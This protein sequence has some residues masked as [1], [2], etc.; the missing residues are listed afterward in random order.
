MQKN[1]TTKIVAIL[2]A[3]LMVIGILPLDINAAGIPNACP[4]EEPTNNYRPAE[5]YVPSAQQGS[6]VQRD[7]E[8]LGANVEHTENLS[9]EDETPILKALPIPTAI[10]GTSTRAVQPADWNIENLRDGDVW[11]IPESSKLTRVLQGEPVRQ[12]KIK[13]VGSYINTNGRLV[14]R[15]SLD[16]YFGSITSVWH[17]LVLKF[18]R[19]FDNLIEWD[20]PGTGMYTGMEPYLYHDVTNKRFS[21]GEEIRPFTTTYTKNVGTPNAHVMNLYENHN[22]FRIGL[23]ETFTFPFELV[24]NE[25][26]QSFEDLKADF[27]EEVLVQARLMSKDFS[28]IY[29]RIGDTDI[30]GKAGGIPSYNTYTLTTVIPTRIDYRK[31]LS[32]NLAR[33][34]SSPLF[35]MSGSY[36]LYNEQDGYVDVFYKSAKGSKYSSSYS[37]GVELGFRQA[38]DKAFYDLLPEKGTEETPAGI[39]FLTNQYDRPFADLGS[40]NSCTFTKDDIN[41]IGDKVGYLQIAS[42]DW[43]RRHEYKGG[44]KTKTVSRKLFTDAIINGAPSHG[45]AGISTV[46][47]Y[48]VDKAKLEKAIRTKG[49]E[50]FSFFSTFVIEDK[51]GTSVYSFTADKEYNIKKGDVLTLIFDQEQNKSNDEYKQIIIGKEQASIEFRSNIIR[52]GSNNQFKWTSPVNIRIPKGETVTVKSIDNDTSKRAQKLRIATT[53]GQF[54]NFNKPTIEYIP[55]SLEWAD[56]LTGG[57]LAK[58]TYLLDIKE[59]FDTDKK[60]EGNSYYKN[61]E[62]RLGLYNEAVSKS[63]EFK[64]AATNQ[65]S[66]VTLH[67]G[68][69]IGYKFTT[70]DPNPVKKPDDYEKEYIKTYPE[71]KLPVLK[72]DMPI[73]ASVKNVEAASLES[74]DVIEQVQAKIIFDL[75]NATRNKEK[76][77]VTKIVPLNIEYLY[78][79][80]YATKTFTKNDAYKYNGFETGNFRTATKWI[81]TAPNNMPEKWENVPDLDIN[82]NKQLA[83]HNNRPLTGAALKSRKMPVMTGENPEYTNE[84][85]KFLGWSTKPN[86]SQKDFAKAKELT[87][88]KQWK[89]QKAYKF[90]GK[91]PIDASYTVYAVW[92]QGVNL[93]LYGNKD[94]NDTEVYTKNVSEEDLIYDTNGQPFVFNNKK[95]AKLRIPKVFYNRDKQ[96]DLETP[97]DKAIFM[98]GYT[99]DEKAGRFVTVNAKGKLQS[100]DGVELTEQ[101]RQALLASYKNRYTMVG[102]TSG[103]EQNI[104]DN[105]IKLY[106]NKVINGVLDQKPMEEKINRD[107]DS[108]KYG[109]SLL[110]NGGNLLIP[111]GEDGKAQLLEDINLYAQY[112]PYYRVQIQ[113]K[114]FD[115]SGIEIPLNHSNPSGQ[116]PD[117]ISSPTVQIGLLHRTAVTELANPTVD[118]AADYYPISKNDYGRDALGLYMQYYESFNPNPKNSFSWYVPG[119]DEYGQRLSYVGVEFPVSSNKND[120]LREEVKNLNK[121]YNFYR[122]WS[123]V[124]ATLLPRTSEDDPNKYPGQKGQ[125][126]VQT[127]LI[128]RVHYG[129]KKVDT[130]TGSTQRLPVPKGDLTKDINNYTQAELA[131]AW[132][133]YLDAN[134]YEVYGYNII[135]TNTQVDKY[136]PIIDTVKKGDKSFIMTNFFKTT[137]QDI[138][139]EVIK[140]A[141]IEIKPKADSD[142]GKRVYHLDYNPNTGKLVFTADDKWRKTS[143]DP[144][145]SP[146]PI[147]DINKAEPTEI[148]PKI[149]INGNAVK[150]TMPETF[151]G[152]EANTN[153]FNVDPNAYIKASYRFN[154][155][156]A[157]FFT[158]FTRRIDDIKPTAPVSVDPETLVQKPSILDNQTNAEIASVDES[159]DI[160][161]AN[162]PTHFVVETKVPVP[163]LNKP[164]EGKTTYYLY[165]A[166]EFAGV[167]DDKFEE[168]YKNSTTTPLGTYQMNDR[169]K[170]IRF[171]VPIDQ[172]SRMV[173]DPQNTNKQIQEIDDLIIVG[174]E[175]GK[176]PSRS[177]A[178]RLDLTG[179]KFDAIAEEDNFRIFVNLVAE[180]LDNRDEDGTYTVYMKVG[181]ETKKF[182]DSQSF[183][184]YYFALEREGI[185]LATVKMVAFD[186][187]NNKTVKEPSYNKTELIDL[188]VSQPKARR[189]VVSAKSILGATIKVVVRNSYNDIVATGSAEVTNP[190]RFTR[191]KLVATEGGVY[192]LQEG[193]SIFVRAVDKLKPETKYSNEVFYEVY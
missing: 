190:E 101:E 147:N 40:T 159:K 35:F 98:K 76:D 166:S 72:K 30:S 69:Y 17:N 65:P 2:L 115:K 173:A 113:K 136:A 31:D 127:L 161:D 133:K 71:I 151:P 183:K 189:K 158:P 77:T 132:Q 19:A 102:W 67:D 156:K 87:D 114:T 116:R 95:Y 143:A 175:A 83:D 148:M 25:K 70:E 153:P 52:D 122:D 3:A 139:T 124:G 80:D 47:R 174:V 33:E 4:V 152:F 66:K 154:D 36:I 62:I 55:R 41:L 42:Q 12:P 142:T 54:M 34:G 137:D 180:K 63:E 144:Q 14:L 56:A 192:T 138:N 38:M 111:V 79:Y 177:Q 29:L 118:E 193:D 112:R 165:K 48:Y 11:S 97:E 110:P 117:D 131:N 141:Q 96:G 37:R 188:E 85:M 130:F 181:N 81:N 73:I 169:N 22:V 6:L 9:N 185:D 5:Q 171:V 8:P 45:N 103:N 170:P 16:S 155:T 46:T 32:Y 167:S 93:N 57:A 178:F 90:T 157:D 123:S 74:D 92:G 15:M 84:E 60:I 119:Y 149:E 182:T 51:D 164:A 172:V 23:R 86:T 105:N 179:P 43:D 125:A 191:V 187:F 184:Q 128:N 140:G 44:V 100:P 134:K 53:N 106:N 20:N 58:S 18:P 88:V 89:E 104:I 135:M 82:G 24:M 50:F 145:N 94:A 126:K 107:K 68:D 168:A 146:L 1:I 186:K 108:I 64:L 163:L 27:P 129:N 39:V 26:Y 21:L 121:Y 120:F 61:G 160:V 13:Y 49:L 78:N 176:K 10:P 150:I 59:V 109:R 99:D 162:A 7:S 75:D 91:S 28:Q